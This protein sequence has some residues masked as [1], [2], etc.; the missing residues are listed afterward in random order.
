MKIESEFLRGYLETALFTT[1]PNPPSGVDYVSSGRAAELLPNLPESFVAKAKADCERF[2]I[3]NHALLMQAGDEWR[4]GSDFWYTRNGHGVGF[5]DRDY[6][7]H[8]ADPLTEAAQKFGE[9]HD[10]CAEDFGET[11]TE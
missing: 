4:N 11:T 10:F 9:V 2:Q 6:P 3:E 8:V 1:D 7:D 5:W